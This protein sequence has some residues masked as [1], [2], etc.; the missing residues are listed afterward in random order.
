VSSR[1]FEWLVQLSSLAVRIPLN[2]MPV[3]TGSLS[4]ECEV[5]SL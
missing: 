3:I 2:T 4:H 1:Y 5:D